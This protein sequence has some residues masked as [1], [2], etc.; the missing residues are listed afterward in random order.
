MSTFALKIIALLTMLTDHAGH[1]V[2]SVYSWEFGM[3]LRWIGR[4]A[5]PLYAFLIGQGCKHTKDIKKYLARLL[6]FAFISEIPFDLFRSNIGR[7]GWLHI[8]FMDF[9]HQNVFFT[10]FL[11][12]LVIAV[13]LYSKTEYVKWQSLIISAVAMFCAV[14]VAGFLGTDYGGEGVI[15]ISLPFIVADSV[16]DERVQ[17]FLYLAFMGACLF[18]IYGSSGT[19]IFASALASLVF[20]LFYNGTKGRNLKWFFYIIYPAHLLVLFG[21]WFLFFRVTGIG[22]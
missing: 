1:V 11:G 19:V 18:M 3:P 8:N 2:Q 9:S 6:L 7:P 12:G 14:F 4:V 22:I 17:K 15:L 5:F 16:S 21:I 13:Y 20:V 10:L